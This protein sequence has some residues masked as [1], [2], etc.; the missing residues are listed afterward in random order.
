MKDLNI[1]I[2]RAK[3]KVVPHRVHGYDEGWVDNGYAHGTP[4]KA[5]DWLR[6]EDGD[7]EDAQRPDERYFMIEALDNETSGE[8]MWTFDGFVEIDILTLS[9]HFPDIST[10]SENVWYTIEEI[11]KIVKDY[12]HGK[13]ETD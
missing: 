3:K 8:D 10:T 7:V 4:I 1:P 11:S 13:L 9:I 5:Y 6:N 2:Y 12:E